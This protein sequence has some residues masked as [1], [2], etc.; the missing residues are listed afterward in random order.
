MDKLTSMID[1]IYREQQDMKRA[2][3]PRP[4]T[5]VPPLKMRPGSVPTGH[6]QR[7]TRPTRPMSVP[8]KP[9]PR[10]SQ[11]P[12]VQPDKLPPLAPRPPSGRPSSQYRRNSERGI[13]MF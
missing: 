2:L 4:P 5:T 8:T 9:S 3:Q 13:L 6:P 12:R 1:L 10:Q 7:P 11:R